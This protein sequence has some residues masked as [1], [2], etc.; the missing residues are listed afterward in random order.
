MLA[1]PSVAPDHGVPQG[2]GRIGRGVED[3]EGGVR[4]AEGGVGVEKQDAG[5]V[6]REGPEDQDA[7]V[8]LEEGSDVSAGAEEV[9][10]M[11]G[12]RRWIRRRRCDGNQH[13][14]GPAP[15]PPSA[16]KHVRYVLS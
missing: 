3:G 2:H 13:V 4:S 12:R 9:I 6:V 1:G 16:H 14:E 15:A 8:E 10:E 11:L 7:G 5:G